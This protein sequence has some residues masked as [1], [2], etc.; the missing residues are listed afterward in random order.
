MIDPIAAINTFRAPRYRCD[1]AHRSQKM[2]ISCYLLLIFT[3]PLFVNA[4][5]GTWSNE[6]EGI[7]GRLH[8]EEDPKSPFLIVSLELKN[9][10]ASRPFHFTP[11]KLR[12]TIKDEKGNELKPSFR[13]DVSGP[14]PRWEDPISILFDSVYKFR[15]SYPTVTPGSSKVGSV[16]CLRYDTGR[17]NLSE[18]GTY[19]ISAVFEDKR[20]K[21]ENYKF[22]W[23]GTLEFPDVKIEV[24]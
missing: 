1:S 4:S 13:H 2:K 3:L 14:V 15:I 10:S 20:I 8:L 21:E 7:S 6:V 16:I 18:S 12:M 19:T 11:K 9:T 17:W 23:H 5:D 22:R 24:Q